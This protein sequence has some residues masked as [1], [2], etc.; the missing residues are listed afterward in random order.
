[1]DIML[2]KL[3][4]ASAFALALST[5]AVFAADKININTA[6]K[7]ELQA[8]SGVG[9]ATADAIIAYREQNGAIKSIDDLVNVKGIGLKKAKKLADVVT[10]SDTE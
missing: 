6:T 9:D 2:N 3:L 8:L 1:M 5:G 10:T 7:A 4:L